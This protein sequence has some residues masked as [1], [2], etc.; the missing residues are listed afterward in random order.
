V[1]QTSSELLSL[2]ATT[3]N[4]TSNPIE[5]RAPRT[6]IAI[7]VF[8]NDERRLHQLL[9]HTKYKEEKKYC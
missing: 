3:I 5:R 6:Q 1:R 4:P 2:F 7:K 9:L 8:S